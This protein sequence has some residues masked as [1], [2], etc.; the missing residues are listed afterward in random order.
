M[1]H[2]RREGVSV[3]KVFH[4][5]AGVCGAGNSGGDHAG[6][7]GSGCGPA[8]SA[9]YYHAGGPGTVRLSYLA[10]SQTR[11]AGEVQRFRA[12][13][14][15]LSLNVRADVAQLVEHSLGKLRRFGGVS[16]AGAASR[17]PERS[18]GAWV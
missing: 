17:N 16:E 10:A 3:V 11:A 9:E 8:S 12:Q 13:R 4:R 2:A 14:G 7:N 5:D 18:E 6:S 1:L 15:S